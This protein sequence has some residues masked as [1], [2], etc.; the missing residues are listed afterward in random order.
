MRYDATAPSADMHLLHNEID[1]ALKLALQEMTERCR[2]VFLM[3][4]LHGL[5]YNEIADALHVSV[6]TI[7]ADMGKALRHLRAR[8]ATWLPQKSAT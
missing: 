3:N 1:A 6:K 5:T 8:L 4:R 2:E 7:E